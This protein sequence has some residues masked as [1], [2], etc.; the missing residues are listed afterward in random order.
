VQYRRT[1]NEQEAIM[2]TTDRPALGALHHVAV[3]V[4]DVEASAEWY[5]RV[6]GL[7]RLPAPIP[8]YG[9]QSPGFGLLLLDP[10]AGWAIGVH[11]HDL[12]RGEAADETRTGMDHIGLAV[13]ERRDLDDWARRL[14]ALGGNHSGV[15]DTA[16]P[17]PYS[18]LV[19]R[20]PDN[21]QLEF[22][23]LP[24]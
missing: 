16:D 8:H 5:E 3:T 18:T 10:S 24:S 15:T 17:I 21:I 20:D 12:H 23:H 1:P 9:N 14:D 19:F 11:H 2:T 22:V 6:L 7:Q 13:P 4:T